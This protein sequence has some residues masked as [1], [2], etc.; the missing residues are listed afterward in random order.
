MS[1]LSQLH[2]V[3]LAPADMGFRD[4]HSA[5]THGGRS[6]LVLSTSAACR[7][8]PRCSVYPCCPA[9]PIRPIRPL[10]LLPCHLIL[11]LFMGA[12]VLLIPAVPPPARPPPLLPIAIS[13]LLYQFLPRRSLPQ[14]CDIPCQACG[15]ACGPKY[16]LGPSKYRLGPPKYRLGP[17]KVPPG[18]PQALP[19]NS[20]PGGRSSRSCGG[21]G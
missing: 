19:Q 9:L 12:L 20:P 18:P 7:A 10:A 2:G 21:P 13:Y 3:L 11:M 14:H 17:P 6:P 8:M 15:A 16:S 5:E 4:A 1:A